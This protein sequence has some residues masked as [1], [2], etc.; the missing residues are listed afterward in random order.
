MHLQ[1]HPGPQLRFPQRIVDAN[2]RHLDDVCGSSLDR[3]VQ[4]VGQ[5]RRQAALEALD[6]RQTYGKVMVRVAP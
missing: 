3:R 4:R 1:Q 6:T 5:R 2:H